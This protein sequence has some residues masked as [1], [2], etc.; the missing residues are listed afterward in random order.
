MT[1]TTL[2]KNVVREIRYSSLPDIIAQPI[3]IYSLETVAID[4]RQA[5]GALWPNECRIVSKASQM[6]MTIAK[7]GI[8]DLRFSAPESILPDEYESGFSLLKKLGFLAESETEQITD[9]EF[10]IAFTNDP[11]CFSQPADNIAKNSTLFK[12][13]SHR[14]SEVGN[15]ILQATRISAMKKSR[16][17]L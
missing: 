9:Q 15:Q 17:A 4:I 10:E 3:E 13:L 11:T 8:M 5:L 7:Y 2:L 1:S 12:L 16:I 14:R 6:A